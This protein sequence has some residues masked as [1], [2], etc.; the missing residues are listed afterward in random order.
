MIE[1][2]TPAQATLFAACIAAVAS[3]IVCILNNRAQGKKLL[4]ELQNQAAEKSASEAARD[5]RLEMWM[6]T[7]DKKLDEHNGYAK[8]FEEIGKDIAVIKNDIRT[9]YRR[10][11]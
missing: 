1:A 11:S 9:L 10:D 5:A 4:T 8:R 7:V 6:Q 3:L 2:L